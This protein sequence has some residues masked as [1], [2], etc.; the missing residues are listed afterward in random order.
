MLR[1]VHR[2]SGIVGLSGKDL[3][4]GSIVAQRAGV[5]AALERKQG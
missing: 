5:I 1:H 3:A 2:L 4:G